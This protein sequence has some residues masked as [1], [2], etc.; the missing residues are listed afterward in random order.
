LEEDPWLNTFSFSSS[1]SSR[2]AEVTEIPSR[3]AASS[4]LMDPCSVTCLIGQKHLHKGPVRTVGATL[5]EF[6][7]LKHR[8]TSVH[9][10]VVK[11]IL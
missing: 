11:G 3:D 4:L 9:P 10:T 8:M 6:P 5:P 7:D 2:Q 1:S